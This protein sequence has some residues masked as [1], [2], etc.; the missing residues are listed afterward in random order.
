MIEEKDIMIKA[1]N[2]GMRFNLGIEKGFSAKQ[3]FIELLK[4]K[5][6]NK[7]K[8]EFWALSGIDFEIKKGEVVGLIGSNGAGK[9]TFLKIIAGVMKPTKGEIQVKGNVC[10]MIELGAGF[11]YDLTAKENIY[12][13]GAILGYSKEFIDKKFNDIV[14]FSELNNFLE[15]PVKNFSSGMIARLAFSIATIVDPEILIVDEILSVGDLAFQQKSEEKMRSMIGGGTTVLYVSH[16]VDSIKSL[17]N[18]VIW[19]EHGKIVEIGQPSEVCDKYQK[20]VL[21]EE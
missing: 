7:K 9:S 20:T 16:S 17:C 11:D 1:K 21:K 8:N 2:V 19:L 15:V 13:N 5:R 10:P 14:N 3:F 12:L 4:G 18:K 6:R